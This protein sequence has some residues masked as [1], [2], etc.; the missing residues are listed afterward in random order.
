MYKYNKQLVFTFKVRNFEAISSCLLRAN[1][2]QTQIP[3]IG[4]GVGAT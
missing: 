1:P 4:F 3:N 2:F